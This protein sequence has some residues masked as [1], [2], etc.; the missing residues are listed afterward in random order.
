MR[1]AGCKVALGGVVV[2]QQ[3]WGVNLV[4]LIVT[5]QGCP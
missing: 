3:R 4:S 5:L 2:G 1:G